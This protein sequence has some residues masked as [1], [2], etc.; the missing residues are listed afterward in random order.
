ME[1]KKFYE[2]KEL[3][4][5]LPISD[6]RTIT[7]WLKDNNIPIQMIAGRKVVHRFMVDAEIDQ[8]LVWELKQKYPQKWRE[9]Y[10]C[11]RNNDRLEYLE[12]ID[13]KFS[14]LNTQKLHKRIEPKS[15]QS[16]N[17]LKRYRR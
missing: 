12:L 17:F 11:Y 3:S 13:D 1:N 6:L 16:V 4:D 7:K 10:K 14:E 9:L 2:L 5:L 15:E 8:S